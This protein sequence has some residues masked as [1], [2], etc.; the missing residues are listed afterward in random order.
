[1]LRNKTHNINYH[2][3]L[4]KIVSNSFIN[5]FYRYT[6]LHITTIYCYTNERLYIYINILCKVIHVYTDTERGRKINNNFERKIEFEFN[7]YF[8]AKILNGAVLNGSGQKLI[9]DENQQTIVFVYRYLQQHPL[10]DHYYC[11]R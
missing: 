10:M 2:N 8:L 1:M 3:T 6:L 9:G 11:H 7:N 4:S 5:L